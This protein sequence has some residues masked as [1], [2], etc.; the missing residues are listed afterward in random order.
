MNVTVQLIAQLAII[1]GE[2]TVASL[3]KRILTL[4]G[5]LSAT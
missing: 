2:R 5:D 4:C 3:G 1:A